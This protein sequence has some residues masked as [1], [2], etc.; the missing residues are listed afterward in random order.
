RIRTDGGTQPRAD[1]IDTLIVDYVEAMQEDA[2]FPPV[3]VFYDGT[4]YWLADGFHRLAAC[5][6]LGRGTIRCDLRQGTLADAVWYSCGANS[7]HG[8]RRSNKDKRRAVETALRNKNVQGLSN[9]QIAKHCG[10]SHTYV[11]KVKEELGWHDVPKPEVTLPTQSP[12]QRDA[13]EAALTLPRHRRPGDSE[14]AETFGIDEKLVRAAR[15]ELD[16]WVRE[17]T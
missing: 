6:E 1:L 8:Q 3:S 16:E 13:L 17:S 9:R 10:V 7:T 4:H 2:E 15:E 12:E 11:A 5:R 14:L